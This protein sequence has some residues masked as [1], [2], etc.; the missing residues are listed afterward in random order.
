METS[1][2]NHQKNVATFIHLSVFA[3]FI[4]PLGNFIAP[5]LI[6]A[7]LKKESIYVDN[8]GRRALNFQMSTTLYAI[9]I[10]LIAIPFILWQAINASDK[11]GNIPEQ[12]FESFIIPNDAIGLIV[13]GVVFGILLLALC[14]LSL[15]SVISA[16]VSASNGEIYKYPLSI[17]FLKPLSVSNEETPLDSSPKA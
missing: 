9:A 3:Q 10:I 15:F 1:I 8:H 12:S 6:W 16:A 4:I 5:L 7:A 2:T 11:L 17:N 13:I 14:I